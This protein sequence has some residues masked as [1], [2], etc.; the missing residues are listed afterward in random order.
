M[1]TIADDASCKPGSRKWRGTGADRRRR[2]AAGCGGG[3]IKLDD[4]K[5]V[6]RCSADGVVTTEP[7]E[8][9]LFFAEARD[10]L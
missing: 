4:C 10:F 5:Y 6:P 7:E 9:V 8:R 2:A 1:E 3:D